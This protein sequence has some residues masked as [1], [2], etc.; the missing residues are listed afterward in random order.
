M[1]M[2]KQES[3]IVILPFSVILDAYFE[4][5]KEFGNSF[6]KDTHN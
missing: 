3:S 2:L 4:I 1:H 6:K 5:H